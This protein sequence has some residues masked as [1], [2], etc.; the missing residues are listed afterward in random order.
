MYKELQEKIA[1][2]GVE[3]SVEQID[4]RF[5]SNRPVIR[6]E[7]GEFNL[8][9]HLVDISGVCRDIMKEIENKFGK[10]ILHD[11]VF[12]GGGSKK[13]IKVMEDKM[14]NNATVPTELAW[15]CNSIGYLVCN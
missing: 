5:N 9:D 15:C 7:K 1:A 3:V 12:V 6:T 4:R 2:E 13:L 14:K 11:K 10:T 8:E